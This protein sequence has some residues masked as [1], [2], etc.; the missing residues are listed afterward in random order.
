M[1]DRSG[2]DPDTA[3]EDGYPWL[4]E[5]AQLFGLPAPPRGLIAV[6]LVSG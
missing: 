3:L 6:V 4:G 5:A 2:A 1:A